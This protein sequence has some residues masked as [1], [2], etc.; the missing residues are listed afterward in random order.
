M[1]LSGDAHRIVLRRSGLLA[2]YLVVVHGLALLLALAAAWSWGWRLALLAVIS[3]S[4]A[5]A[6]HNQVRCRRADCVSALGYGDGDRWTLWLRGGEMQQAR[7]SRFF[8]HPWMVVL[9]LRMQTGGS[10]ALL[11][12]RDCAPSGQLRRLRCFLQTAGPAHQGTA[13]RTMGG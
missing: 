7:L 9:Y 1:A 11:L 3:L 8:L 10:R 6:W 2:A 4:F 12:P 13:R 5:R